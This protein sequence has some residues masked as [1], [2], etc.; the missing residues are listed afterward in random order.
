[1]DMR[2][3]AETQTLNLQSSAVVIQ[4]AAIGG[5]RMSDGEQGQVPKTTGAETNSADDMALLLLRVGRH[6]DRAAFARLYSYYA[7]RLNSYLCRLGTKDGG[8]EELVQE[9]MMIIWRKA[10]MFDPA[11]A[12]AGTWIFTIA[13]NKRIDALRREYR[14][15][16]DHNDPF[17]E[18]EN[19]LSAD[20][21]IENDERRAKI[22]A[23]LDHLPPDQAR[24]VRLSFI[25][26]EPH[27]VISERLGIPL[28]TVKSRIRMAF[29]RLRVSLGDEL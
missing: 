25:E 21:H 6:Q 18:P 27:T 2:L 28:G 5:S 22:R 3:N 7:P 14:P 23:A 16:I 9:T 24:V 8:A 4:L 17:F 29:Q 1:M 15:E 26:D 13:R 10:A 19:E 11:K 12:S 20:Q